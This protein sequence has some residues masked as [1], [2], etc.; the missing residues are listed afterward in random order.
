MKRKLNILYIFVILFLTNCSQNSMISNVTPSE[1]T[2]EV[3]QNPGQSAITTPVLTPA[4]TST[5]QPTPTPLVPVIN[6]CLVVQS[7]WSGASGMTGSLFYA[8]YSSSNEILDQ[9]N[10]SSMKTSEIHVPYGYDKYSIVSPDHTWVAM[11][12]YLDPTNVFVISS[13]GET[14]TWQSQMTH[15]LLMRW[16]DNR[17]FL[18]YQFPV[19]IESR[20]DYLPPILELANPFTGESRELTPNY[21]NPPDYLS[22]PEWM[23]QWYTGREYDP[24]LSRV[25]YL[26]NEQ[27]LIYWDITSE[28]QLMRLENYIPSAVGNPLWSPQGKEFVFNIIK[29][30]NLTFPDIEIIKVDW[31]GETQQITDFRNSFSGKCGVMAMDW[32]PDGKYLALT[33]ACNEDGQNSRNLMLIDLEKQKMTNYCIPSYWEIHWAPDSRYL[34]TTDQIS[35]FDNRQIIVDIQEGQA[36]L[37]MEDVAILGWLK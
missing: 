8:P 15:T 4:P 9:I 17:R 2:I 10:F 5:K 33:V 23:R 30:E 34:I 28:N 24:T 12:Q 35:D 27:S 36:Y 21:P 31:N 3:N 29:T 11:K 1:A 26:D 37:F 19:F 14:F 22:H 16:L 20:N 25:V 6:Q 13:K 32:S 7:E 18:I